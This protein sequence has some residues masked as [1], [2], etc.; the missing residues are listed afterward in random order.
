MAKGFKLVNCVITFD[1]GDGP[2][3][4]GAVQELSVKREDDNT[5]NHQAGLLDPVDITPG[6]RTY[7][8]SVKHLWFETLYIK[9]YQDFNTYSLESEKNYEDIYLDIEGTIQ[10]GS[11]R[12]C[13]IKGVKFRGLDLSMSL[14]EVS[15]FTRDFDAL[16]LDFQ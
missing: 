7:S 13:K 3:I 5:V 15:A 4:I 6:K 12:T 11:N 1:K 8:G 10:D 9:L 14:D 2:K 16:G